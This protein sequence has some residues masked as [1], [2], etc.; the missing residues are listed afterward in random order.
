MINFQK[1][2]EEKLKNKRNQIYQEYKS[3]QRQKKRFNTI[4]E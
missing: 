1:I 3:N 4:E 2:K